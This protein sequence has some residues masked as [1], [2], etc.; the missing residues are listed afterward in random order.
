MSFVFFLNCLKLVCKFVKS[1]IRFNTRNRLISF[2]L[3]VSFMAF[4]LFFMSSI[5]TNENKKLEKASETTPTIYQ[6]I[7]QSAIH[8]KKNARQYPIGFF[9][10][11]GKL[12]R[13]NRKVCIEITI[14]PFSWVKI[15]N[16]LRRKWQLERIIIHSRIEVKEKADNEFW[17][18]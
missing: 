12:W 7:Y 1:E 16:L 10:S 11:N 15:I 4:K 9:E 2:I 17:Q 6:Y 5:S 18:Q 13:L 14:V 3:M 8:S